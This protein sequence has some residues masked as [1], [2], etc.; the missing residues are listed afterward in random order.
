MQR[1]GLLKI[2]RLKATEGI[3][4]KIVWPRSM[5]KQDKK[6]L[7][8]IISTYFQTNSNVVIHFFT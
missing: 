5:C 1:E 7:F 2:I 3:I 6:M 8:Y 4:E